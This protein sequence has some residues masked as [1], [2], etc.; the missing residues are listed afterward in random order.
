MNEAL[1]RILATYY[2]FEVGMFKFY[3]DTSCQTHTL[4]CCQ[5]WLPGTLK[6]SSSQIETLSTVAGVFLS[7]A[8]FHFFSPSLES[9]AQLCLSE[10]NSSNSTFERRMMTVWLQHFRAAARSL[11][12]PKNDQAV[13]L[14]ESPTLL[15]LIRLHSLAFKMLIKYFRL[16]M[17]IR[18]TEW[19]NLLDDAK[20]KANIL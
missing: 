8:L 2:Q 6:C 12:Q 20:N 17:I 11:R 9:T 10:L 15:C 4:C 14:L 5:Q 7:P 18:T 13:L 16:Q 3:P 1:Q 19:E